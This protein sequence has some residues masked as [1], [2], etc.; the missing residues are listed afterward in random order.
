MAFEDLDKIDVETAEFWISATSLC[1]NIKSIDNANQFLEKIKS[2]MENKKHSNL[3]GRKSRFNSLKE[4]LA[5]LTQENTLYVLNQIGDLPSRVNSKIP[6]YFIIGIQDLYDKLCE[7]GSDNTNQDYKDN[8]SIESLKNSL[9]VLAHELKTGEISTNI[10]KYLKDGYTKSR[11]ILAIEDPKNILP[12]LKNDGSN[13][14]ECL[15]KLKKYDLKWK[16]YAITSF[17]E[18][19]TKMLDEILLKEKMMKNAQSIGNKK[20]VP[21]KIDGDLYLSSS[22]MKN[23]FEDAKRKVKKYWQDVEKFKINDVLNLWQE[24]TIKEIDKKLKYVGINDIVKYKDGRLNTYQIGKFMHAIDKLLKKNKLSKENKLSDEEIKILNFL[25]IYFECVVKNNA[26]KEELYGKSNEGQKLWNVENGQ[27]KFSEDDLKQGMIGD[28]YLI[29]TLMGM[30]QSNPKDILKCFPNS[31]EEVDS[32]GRS[33]KGRVTVQL[34]QVVL[35]CSS[36]FSNNIKASPTRK[37]TNIEIKFS[38][39]LNIWSACY[40]NNSKVFW[41]NFIEQAVTVARNIKNMVV[42]GQDTIIDRRYWQQ[43]YSN[44][45]VI[46]SSTTCAVIKAMLTGHFA[47][48]AINALDFEKLKEN[49]EKKNADMK[50][51]D[52][53]DYMRSVI[54]EKYKKK[55]TKKELET[56]KF[57]RI[58][59]NAKKIITVST[60]SEEIKEWKPSDEFK[61][62]IKDLD[63]ISSNASRNFRTQ[64]GFENKTSFFGSQKFFKNHEYTVEN[65]SF[66]RESGEIKIMLR[67]PWNSDKVEGGKRVVLDL[68]KFCQYFNEFESN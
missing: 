36:M 22:A 61:R 58:K 31:L 34:H 14:K 29:A 5:T 4:I 62:K 59:L 64:F 9:L 3:I 30:L 37:C 47:I 33:I 68:K 27:P 2:K 66:D 6:S 32:N 21:D 8:Y 39:V 55:Y 52:S 23:Q 67:N 42:G 26:P 25:R 12:R 20:T 10:K 48:G 13:L 24:H 17:S 45:K 46:E 19:A 65:Y 63:G 16:I 51:K 56:F 40:S 28:C 50:K 54:T 11:E 43:N 60:G 53:K 41:P 57:I 1:R 49:I 15:G 18:I 7:N 38:T 44:L 35:S